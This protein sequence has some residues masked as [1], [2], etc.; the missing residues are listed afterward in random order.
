MHKHERGHGNADTSTLHLDADIML[1][2]IVDNSTDAERVTL[3][4]QRVFTGTSS[5]FMSTHACFV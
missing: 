2:A 4:E 3:R 5:M 1:N